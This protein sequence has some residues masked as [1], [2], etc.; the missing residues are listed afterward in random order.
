MVNGDGKVVICTK[1][2]NSGLK[3]DF[4]EVSGEFGGLGKTVER[5][6]RSISGAMSKPV[7]EACAKIQKDISAT[8]RRIKQYLQQIQK[9]ESSKM[10]LVEQA[11]QLGAELD[12]AKAKLAQ[13]QVQQ[14]AA[15]NILSTADGQEMS[16]A[17]VQSYLNA[18]EQ[19]PQLDADVAK[20]QAQV[21]A[22]QK[23]WDAVNDKIDAYNSKI[24]QANREME[25]Q[26]G[27][28]AE[29]AQKLD[30]AEKKQR[31][32]AKTRPLQKRGLAL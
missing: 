31:R 7:S 11:E 24:N 30:S 12:T 9:A 8:E 3:K 29:L 25:E 32:S 2:D 4:K 20:Q 16:G 23:K 5:C 18:Y 26:K 19:K 28:A 14:Q 17:D 21:D 22:L 1:L 10:P 15:G 6:S 27:T 13:L